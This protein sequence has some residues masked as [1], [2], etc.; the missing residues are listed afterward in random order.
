MRYILI[1]N[2]LYC[3][4]RYLPYE[5]IY[6]YLKQQMGFRGYPEIGLDIR[7]FQR[8]IKD[9]QEIFG[10]SIKYKRGKGYYIELIDDTETI[11]FDQLLLNFDLL[12]S[13]GADYM[14]MGYILPEHH[15]PKGYDNIYPLFDAIKNNLVVRFNYTLFRNGEKKISK[16]VKPYFLKESLGFWYL[17]CMNENNE[18]RVL[19]ID[20]MSN[21]FTTGKSFKR[22]KDIYF[23]KMFLHSYGIWDDPKLPVEEVVL[24][25]THLDG[26]FL[27]SVP[28]HSSQEILID[29]ENEFRI[30]LHVKITNDFVMALLS[31]SESLTVIKPMSLR[32]RIA[33]IYRD[34]LKRNS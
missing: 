3:N 11:K 26:S 21:L 34:A 22:R 27:K 10:I 17:I 5:D 31:R 24:S 33:D 8:D 12:T 9:I 30:R 20:R 19:G 32:K 29:N 4:D 28:L 2:F 7:T 18:L 1:A 14:S 16:E 6:R 15:R 13:V 23:S 25:Y